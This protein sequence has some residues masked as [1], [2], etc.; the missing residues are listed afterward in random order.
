MS[1]ELATRAEPLTGDSKD[2]SSLWPAGTSG[3]VRTIEPTASFWFSM[4]AA[5][6]LGT[7]LGDYWTDELSLGLGAAFIL[8]AVISVAAMASDRRLSRR[9]EVFY[10]IA[11][12]TLRAAAT[13]IADFLT[14]E[15]AISFLLVASAFGVVAIVAATTTLRGGERSGSP[16]IDGRY[17]A[18][19]FFAGMF[20][21]AGG[22]LTSLTIGL[23]S[24][25][26][27]LGF[28]LLAVLAARYAFAR[29]SILAYWFVIL[30]ERATGT[31]VGDFLQGDDGLR[32][33]LPVSMAC[34]GALLLAG[35]L[36][37]RHYSKKAVG[38]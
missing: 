24:A 13:N 28:V 19:M 26:A 18:T 36:A 27:L 2:N 38:K 21:T 5:S 1:S 9:T 16:N 10:W 17:W 12:V 22:D 35:L 3:S 30:A 34:T 14:H 23:Q 4:L 6:A 32:L 31:P 29:K 33:G 15:H 8:M 25:A 20:G 11:I 7:N 37:H